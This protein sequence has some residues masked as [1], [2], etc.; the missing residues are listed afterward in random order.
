MEQQAVEVKTKQSQLDANKRYRERVQADEE[1]KRY[2]NK[3]TTLRSARNHIRNYSD[4][5]SLLELE[6]LI[7]E[8]REALRNN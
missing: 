6:Q 1:K 7:Q 5:D 4:E 2:R 3:M 8:R